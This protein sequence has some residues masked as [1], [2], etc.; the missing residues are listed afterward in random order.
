[1]LASFFKRLFGR[2]QPEEVVELRTD[3]GRVLKIPW[4]DY[5]AT[6]R[7]RAAARPEDATVLRGVAKEF[8]D[9]RKY[10]L[11]LPLLEDL[12]MREDSTDEDAVLRARALASLGRT[13]DAEAALRRV[14]ETQPRSTLALVD[15][16]RLLRATGKRDEALATARTA[17]E[18]DPEATEPLQVLFEIESVASPEAAEKALRA[19]AA[20]HPKSCGALVVLGLAAEAADPERAAKAYEE[21]F[22]R[23]PRNEQLLACLTS[24]LLA[25]GR[26]E[27]LIQRFDSQVSD[28][29]LMEFL[30]YA[31]LAE[32][33]FA[34]GNTARVLGIYNERIQ[35]GPEMHGRLARQKMAELKE[36]LAKQAGR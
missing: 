21:G 8:M 33:H 1:M 15:L 29:Y 3:N 23:N 26:L 9:W 20:A 18:L 13:Q 4:S 12:V 11:A 34:R 22:S 10:E 25:R 6:L 28:G 5:E 16:A 32:A 27:E 31:N 14:L 19:V 24:N 17:V 7:K 2:S 35:R 30:V 36:R